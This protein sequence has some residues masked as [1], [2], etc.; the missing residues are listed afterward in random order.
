[1]FIASFKMNADQVAHLTLEQRELRALA[2]QTAEIV[3]FMTREACEKAIQSLLPLVQEAVGASEVAVPEGLDNKKGMELIEMLV[4]RRQAAQSPAVAVSNKKG[5]VTSI[6]PTPKTPKPPPPTP[7]PTP[8]VETRRSKKKRAPVDEEKRGASGTGPPRK[9]SKHF[10]SEHVDVG[11]EEKWVPW[12]MDQHGNI[13]EVVR[14]GFHHGTYGLFLEARLTGSGHRKTFPFFADAASLK[15][16]D[17]IEERSKYKKVTKI[18]W[19]GIQRCIGD[20]K[21]PDP[22]L[23]ELL[24]GA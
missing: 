7:M 21:G 14:A 11:D 6:T 18:L 1:M 23:T 16:V 17:T 19:K 13:V 20:E 15:A 10:S 5:T 12:N 9:Q 24:Q 22:N 3:Q 2:R 4:Q 8:T